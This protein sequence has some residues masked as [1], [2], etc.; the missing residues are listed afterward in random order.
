M[1]TEQVHFKKMP[2]FNP[3]TLEQETP[4]YVQDEDD[5]DDEDYDEDEEASAEEEY[6]DD[7]DIEDDQPQSIKILDFDDILD[8][9]DTAE[10]PFFVKEWGGSIVIKGITKSEFDHLRRMARNKQNRG[11]SNYVIER[12]VLL[13]GVV[14]PRLDPAKFN[15]LQEKSSGAIL[16]I[17][18]KILDKSGLADEAENKREQRFPR[19]R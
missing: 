1:E 4:G 18:N 7:N 12:E 13:A 11:R 16:R 2:S 14:T 17:M 5:Y 8:A 19:K 9:D 6:G 15:R 10:E 3:E